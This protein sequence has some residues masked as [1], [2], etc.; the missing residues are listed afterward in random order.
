MLNTL[1]FSTLSVTS[2]FIIYLAGLATSFTPCIYP[3]VPI[4]VGYLGNQTG[5]K[6]ER[7]LTCVIYTLGMSL[8]YAGLGL[9][10]AAT[11]QLFGDLTATSPVYIIF[12]LFIMILGG[13]MMDWYQ[14]PLPSF[15]QS[16]TRGQDEKPSLWVSFLVGASS[17]AVSSPCTAPVLGGILTYVAA[18]KSYFS[19]A[20][21]MFFFALGMNTLLLLL[22]SSVSLLR[23]IPKSG[24]WMSRI[25]KIMAFLLIA[26]GLYFVFKAGQI[27]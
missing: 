8:V 23:M 22:G 20:L 17:G 25:K 19:G 4:V 6:K 11:G 7:I 18:S 1:D 2:V 14:I 12:G 15:L 16:K 24:M 9:L 5:S 13:S 3:M 10:A 21:L 26:G 27:S